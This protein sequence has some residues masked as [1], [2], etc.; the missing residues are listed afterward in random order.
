MKNNVFVLLMMLFC[1]TGTLSGQEIEPAKD[2]FMLFIPVSYDYARLEEQ[3]L[4]T[5]V[6][7]IGFMLGKQG[8]P[9]DEV[10]HRF[11]GIAQYQTLIFT[12][13]LQNGL[14][15]QFHGISAMLDGRINRHQILAVFQTYSDKP[16]SGLNTFDVGAG[17]GYE[18]IRRPHV[19][20]ILGAALMVGDKEIMGFSSPVMPMP[21]VR[22]GLDTKWFVSTIEY[23]GDVHLAFTIAP[24]EKIRFTA[25][26]RTNSFNSIADV[27]CKFTLWYRL[28]AADYK[29]GDFFGIGAGFK[30]EVL[31]FNLSNDYR[32]DT[33]KLQK[34]S[35][36]A[37]IELFSAIQIQG[38][39]VI[40]SNYLIDGKKVDSPGNGFFLSV[41]GM[42]PVIMKM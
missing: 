19:S 5:P 35:V 8:I 33:F 16:V 11:L 10:E 40:D 41:S 12:E 30:N 3:T 39:W 27:N 9:F 38:G 21:V 28:F 6:A 31:G 29:M 7:G 14:P 1:A 36:F 26:M 20:L 42:I 25:D 32:A 18:V 17:Y 2:P 4:H 37:A 13:T 15:K 23:V 24:K 22:F 34:A